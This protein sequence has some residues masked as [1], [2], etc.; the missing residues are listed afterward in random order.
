MENSL[1]PTKQN[2][3]DI[4]HQYIYTNGLKGGNYGYGS[5]MSAIYFVI[6]GV[7]MGVLLLLTRKRVF[8]YV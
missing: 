3:S 1:L 4:L 7:I 2:V 8:Y 5:A 6:V